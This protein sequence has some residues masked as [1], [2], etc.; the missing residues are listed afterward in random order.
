M[1]NNIIVDEYS[2]TGE[3]MTRKQQIAR[4]VMPVLVTLILCSATIKSFV[5]GKIEFILF[6]LVFIFSAAIVKDFP[7]L[8]KHKYLKVTLMILGAMLLVNGFV[9]EFVIK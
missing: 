7:R 9:I 3:K 4:W 2:E 6:S 1:T 5:S 8:A